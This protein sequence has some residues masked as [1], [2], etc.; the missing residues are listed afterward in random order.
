MRI[1]LLR[2]HFSA[3]PTSSNFSL[4][5]P[6]HLTH[7]LQLCSNSR[8]LIQ[9][10]QCHLQII[11]HGLHQEPFIVTKLVQS[12][13]ECD[14]LGY[15]QKL[16]DV[17]PEPNV[18][19]WTAVL[20]F[21]SRNGL[22]HECLQVYGAMR[23]EG[24]L[25]DQYV[26]PKVLRA[27]AQLSVL[28]T[29]AMVHKEVI[30]CGAKFNLQ[31]CS[32]LIDMYSKCNQVESAR[33]VFDN[34]A[35]RDLLSWN[36]MISGCVANG[37]PASAV[38]LFGLMTFAGIKPDLVTWNSVMD[39]YCRMGLCDEA[40]RVFR[41][42]LQPNIISWTTLISGFSRNGDY[43]AS[44]QIFRNMM[45]CIGVNPDLDSLSSAIV[46]CRYLRALRNGQEI[47]AYGMK[48]HYHSIF[49]KSAGPA[50]LTICSKCGRVHDMKN[51]F[52]LMEKV[53]V[54]TWNAM[55]F[56]LI[57]LAMGNSAL[58]VFTQ[59]QSVGIRNDQT[60]IST[61][62][63]ICDLKS[64][65][66]I[67]AYI[68]RNLYSSVVPVL[69]AL[70]S[71]YCK[72]GS[73]DSANLVFSNMLIRDLVSWNTMIGGFAMHGK[74][75][76]A[77][78]LLKDMTSSG[79]CPDTVTLTSALSACSHSGLVDQGL[80]LFYS[81]TRDFEL[82]PKMEHFACLVDILA[83]AGQLNE[84]LD[85]LKGMPMKP[86]KHIWGTLLAAGEAQ[87][88]LEV[89]NLAAENLVSLEPENAGHYVTL[90]NIYAKEEKWDDTMRIRRLMECRG[91]MKPTGRSWTGRQK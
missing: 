65:R 47:H 75:E 27:C 74:G 42:I 79:L 63:P 26:F 10:K 44:L 52:E 55:I 81:M 40:V 83:R 53:D 89:A 16:F 23:R 80:E 56:G 46:S 35:V 60:T 64:G 84:A 91:L 50:L 4:I 22:F 36:G 20:A 7:L 88:N 13:A 77:L 45:N 59:M 58:E 3:Q 33:R 17:L 73:I 34:M 38:E 15:A 43:E 19:A 54:V 76:A 51:V 2:R 32:S 30:V 78:Q 66:Q 70:I 82:V 14:H 25:P 29:G 21:H 49:Y 87:R 9:A 86:D 41:Q 28:D 18:F 72:C 1:W 12:Y 6:S 62:L 37:S 85:V 39:A 8:A 68:I 48:T 31:V 5:S 67:H 71:M 61:I 90:S 57:E 69:N 24:V 11:Q